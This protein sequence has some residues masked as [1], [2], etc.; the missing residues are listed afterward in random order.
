MKKE[1][2]NKIIL[3]IIGAIVFVIFI[4]PLYWMLVT[5]LKSQVEIF[6]IPTPLW[7]KELTFEAFQKQLSASS[8]TLR[9]FKNSAIIGF[10]AMAI[11]TILAIPA[12]YG[13]ARF[14]F[15]GKKVII[16][17]FLI[18]QM[19]PST[20]VLTSLYIMFSGAKLLN[21]YMA[22]I[23]ADATLGIPFSVIILRTYFLS[24][25]KE[26]DEAAKIDGCGHLT[27]F[28]K[29]M[30]PIAKPG[31]VVAAVFSFVY[32]WGDLIYGI[33]FITDPNKRPITSSIY[34][35]VQQ[36][37]TLWNSTMAFG[38]IAIFPVILIFIFMQKYIVS[39]LTNGAVKA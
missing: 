17:L 31:V 33:T 14:K 27:A 18:T 19:L 16:L 30:L 22:P 6:Q 26:L 1:T 8:D 39:G 9:G 7:P 10:G 13:L 5:A 24:I 11:S 36:Y 12:A 38:I 20:L 23:L 3:L 34:N 32:A 4:F 29:I 21:T 15:R 37:Q 28:V 2:K 35:Y 25:P